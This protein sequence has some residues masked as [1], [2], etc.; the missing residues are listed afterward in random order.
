MTRSD[1]FGVHREPPADDR[2][3]TAEDATLHGQPIEDA[4]GQEDAPEVGRPETAA[5]EDDA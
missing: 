5:R 1:D 4:P 3:A 2:S